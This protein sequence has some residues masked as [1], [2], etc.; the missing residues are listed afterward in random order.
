MIKKNLQIWPSSKLVIIFPLVSRWQS[1][2]GL[3]IS[4][5]YSLELC[6]HFDTYFPFSFASCFSF[7]LSYL[8]RPPQT[9][10]L[11]S[12]ISFSWGWFWSPPPVECYEPPSIV[13]HTLCVLDL[14]PWIY[15]SPPLYNHKGFD[16]GHTCMV[17]FLQFKPDFC[18][19]ELMIWTSQIQVLF[20]L[21]AEMYI[22]LSI[23]PLGIYCNETEVQKF[24]IGACW[25]HYCWHQK[26]IGSK[27]IISKIR[28]IKLQFILVMKY[29][30]DI[31]ESI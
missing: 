26:E 31:E 8:L 19:K 12:C 22:D 20:L 6:I 4:P 9:T 30:K 27:R 14:I 7:F 28:L 17:Y 25:L 29:Y 18:S 23:L 2:E 10:T 15:S 3:L 13:L 16:L 21:T 1:L 11:P 24:Y 5:C